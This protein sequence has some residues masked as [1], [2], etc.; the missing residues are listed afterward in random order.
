MLVVI[1][2]WVLFAVNGVNEFAVYITRMFGGYMGQDYKDHI[3]SVAIYL[4]AGLLLSAPIFRKLYD[5]IK[6]NV[7]GL[8]LHI[9]LFWASVIS[10][11]DAAYN[12]FLYFRF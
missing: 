11:V 10:L 9:V 4:T 2:G 7:L 3:V 1:V 8:I 5:R 12:P 6:D